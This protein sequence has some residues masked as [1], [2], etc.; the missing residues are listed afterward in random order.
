MTAFFQNVTELMPVT[1][2]VQLPVAAFLAYQVWTMHV[3]IAR[4]QE[5]IK[6]LETNRVKLSTRAIVNTG[7]VNSHEQRLSLLEYRISKESK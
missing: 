5:Q 7:Q 6:S 3:Q 2:L 1:A 4:L